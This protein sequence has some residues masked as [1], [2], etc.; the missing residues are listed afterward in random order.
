MPLLRPAR[1]PRG[2]PRDGAFGLGRT[3][4]CQTIEDFLACRAYVV[5]RDGGHGVA[6]GAAAH[7]TRADQSR[8]LQ[9]D[10]SG[11]I[12]TVAFAG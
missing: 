1:L 11:A 2:G 5:D 8:F 10:V 12:G 3:S 6:V 9:H 7:F 4:Q